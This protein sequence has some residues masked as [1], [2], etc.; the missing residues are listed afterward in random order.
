MIACHLAQAKSHVR[1]GEAHIASQRLIVAGLG[2]VLSEHARQARELLDRFISM[3]EQH[4][5]DRERLLA[6]LSS[7]NALPPE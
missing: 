7:A 5:A 1:L 4:V 2:A 6:A 3:Q